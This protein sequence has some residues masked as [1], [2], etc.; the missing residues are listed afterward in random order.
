VTAQDLCN[1]ELLEVSRQIRKRKISSLEVTRAML[2]RIGRLDGKLKSYATLTPEL[3]LEAAEQADREIGRGR[4]RGPLHGVPIALKD[5]FH[6]Q[7]IATAAGMPLHKNFVPERDATVARKLK[8][9]GAVLLGKLQMTEGAFSAHHPAIASPVNPWSAEHWTGVSSS[10]SGV[11]TAAGLCYGSLG[12]DT[13]GSI[14]F[15]STMNGLTGMKPTW[16]RVSRAG[17]FALAETMDHIGPMTRSAKDAAAMLG[18][19]AGQ[20]PDDRTAM[21]VPVPDYLA[22]IDQSMRGVRIGIDRALIEAQADADFVRVTDEAAAVFRR[23]GAKVIGIDFPSTDQIVRDALILC[24]VEAAAAHAETYP[25]RAQEYG[26]ALSGLLDMGRRTDAIALA[27]ILPRRSSF[28]GQVAALFDDVDLLLMPAM[29]EAAPTM[30][31]SSFL[32]I[33]PMMLH[34]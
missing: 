18:I 23:H 11:A 30:A 8:E 12:T 24:A 6:T 32:T 13:L 22:G 26:P 5:L 28:A 1:L 29:N 19:I 33:H 2:E 17:V 27:R 31:C 7:G 34:F 15:P 4:N 16:G 21:L 25:S 20:D 9:A 14:R 3:A 10:G